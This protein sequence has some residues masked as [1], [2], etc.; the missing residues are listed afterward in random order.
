MKE[1][2]MDT[3]VFKKAL[4]EY[5]FEKWESSRRNVDEE[6]AD[7]FLALAKEVYWPVEISGS[8]YS[9]ILGKIV[10]PVTAIKLRERVVKTVKGR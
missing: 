7:K 1:H 6:T 2:K 9:K 10:G 4:S 8:K 3:P 5:L